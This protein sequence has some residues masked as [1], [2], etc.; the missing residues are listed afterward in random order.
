MTEKKPEF[1]SLIEQAKNL[2]RTI[3]DSS[4]EAIK[5]NRVFVPVEVKEERMSIC[6]KCE[7]LYKSPT[8][9]AAFNRCMACGCNIPGKVAQ[10]AAKCP[11]NKWMPYKE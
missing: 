7:Y 4:K 10:A 3:T 8:G 9:K 6:S 11:V 1:P 2:A 5:G